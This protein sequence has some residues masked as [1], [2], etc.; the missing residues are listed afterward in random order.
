MTRLIK[1]E[2]W[3]QSSTPTNLTEYYQADEIHWMQMNDST[4][5]FESNDSIP[6]TKKAFV[7]N[8]AK[9]QNPLLYPT[10]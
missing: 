7:M 6:N 2:N 3:I 10:F 5:Y 4:L 1:K 9:I 8:A